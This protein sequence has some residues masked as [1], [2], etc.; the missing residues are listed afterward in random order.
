MEEECDRFK[1]RIAGLEEDVAEAQLGLQTNEIK[2]LEITKL[3]EELEL[4]KMERDRTVNELKNSSANP[5]FS[6]LNSSR[7]NP[8]QDDRK[9][10]R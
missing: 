2:E 7:I 10:I 9:K 8:N 6:N 4:V 3:R 1:D 5:R